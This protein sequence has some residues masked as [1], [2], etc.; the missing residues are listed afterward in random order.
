VVSVPYSD[1][2]GRGFVAE[3]LCRLNPSRVLDVGPGAG[4]YG[5]LVRQVL[6]V[7]VLDAVEAW[8]P[9]VERFGLL[10][11][12]DTVTVEDV[13]RVTKF[14]YDVVIFGDV[15]EHMSRDDAV[16]VY[17]LAR[18]QAKAVIVSMPIIH[19]PQ[20]DEEGNPFEAHVVDH[21]HHEDILEAFEGLTEFRLFDVT[22]VY[23][24]A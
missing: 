1:D 16:S 22:G 18:E 15:L 8:E 13:R 9:Y 14:D 17:G 6:T 11:I 19:Y 2:S 3:V 4:A 20:G 10:N 12:Y 23:V 21:W 24:A 7:D 5:R